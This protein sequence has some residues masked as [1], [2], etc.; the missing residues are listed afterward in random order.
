VIG[1]VVAGLAALCYAELAS[2]VP[3]TG[4]AYTYAFA[5]LGEVFAWIIDWDLLLEFALGA[6]FV[7]RG[8]SGYLANLF[9]AALDVVR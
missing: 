5:T 8:W 4:N 9:G 7:S 6:A 2:S 1:S 3:T